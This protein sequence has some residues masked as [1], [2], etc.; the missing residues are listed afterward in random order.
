MPQHKPEVVQECRVEEDQWGP[1]AFRD[2]EDKTRRVNIS[3]LSSKKKE[4]RGWR[5]GNCQR[6]NG[7]SFFRTGERSSTGTR[8]TKY[9][10]SI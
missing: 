3:N 9:I 2:V 8:S 10:R 4:K 6:E 1:E 7:F 5:R